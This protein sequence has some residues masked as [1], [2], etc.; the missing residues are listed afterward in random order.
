MLLL[1]I[2]QKSSGKLETTG[3]R[4]KYCIGNGNG[5]GNGN[6]YLYRIALQCKST[7]YQRGTV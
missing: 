2:L 7:V 5:N 6:E 4:L 1:S 3:E